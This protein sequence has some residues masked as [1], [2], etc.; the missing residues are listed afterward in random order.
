MQVTQAVIGRYSILVLPLTI[1]DLVK[2]VTREVRRKKG[3]SG[4][5]LST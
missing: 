3:M 4:E 2:N 1:F 5:M